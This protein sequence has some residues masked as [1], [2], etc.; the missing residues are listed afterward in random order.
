MSDITLKFSRCSGFL[1]GTCGWLKE[2]LQTRNAR[3]KVSISKSNRPATFLYYQDGDKEK[4]EALA[5]FDYWGNGYGKHG[6]GAEI[7]QWPFPDEMEQPSIFGVTLTPAAQKIM[8]EL[9]EQAA[10]ELQAEMDKDDN[11]TATA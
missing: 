11:A 4:C 9:A 2:Q 7:E 6:P 1:P 10:I 3:L 8:S 5:I